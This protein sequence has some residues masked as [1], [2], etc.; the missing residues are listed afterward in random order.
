[1]ALPQNIGLRALTGAVF[2]AV[3]VGSILWHPY[4]VGFLFFFITQ[5]GVRELYGLAKE[6]GYKPAVIPGLL[7][8]AMLFLL[9]WADT[10]ALDVEPWSGVL[11]LLLLGSFVLIG[12]GELFSNSEKS[13]SNIAITLLGPIYVVLPFVLLLTFGNSPG[14]CQGPAYDPTMIL[15]F[16][17]LMWTSDTGAYLVGS[18]MGKTKLFERLSPK[19]TW[20]GTIGGGVLA[21]GVAVL[22]NHLFETDML[23]HWI[24]MAVMV[25]I[26]G[27]LGDLFQSMLKRNVGVKDSGKIM[28]GHGGIL[29]RFDA[30]LFAAPMT[31]VAFQILDLI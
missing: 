10:S 25:V 26:F 29:D 3:V 16:F 9:L 19:K 13:I 6:G 23:I 28:P 21:I 1:M 18:T 22:C 20:E 7:V 8:S 31:F 11:G 27:N 17:I 14:D 2:V 30:T 15:G 12:S 5:V 4:A 24:V